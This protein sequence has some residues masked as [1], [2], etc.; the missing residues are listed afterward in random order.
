MLIC[1]ISIFNKKGKELL[2]EMLSEKNFS[3]QDMVILMVLDQSPGSSAKLLGS[4]C[5]TDKANVT[6]LIARLESE[7]Y[8]F[9]KDHPSDKRIKELYLTEKGKDLMPWL[10]E[11]MEAWEKSIFKDLT[12]EELKTYHQ[13]NN[14]IL[15]DLMG[16]NYD[17]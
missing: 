10:Y 6:K 12:E 2:S 4:F 13:L 14:R 17:D 9:K 11:T 15:S 1:S 5:Q 3:W 16:E 8:I 7:D